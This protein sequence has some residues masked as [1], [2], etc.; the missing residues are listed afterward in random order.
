MPRFKSLLSLL[1]LITPLLTG[2]VL[3]PVES[4]AQ[5][6]ALSPAVI[7]QYSAK[8]A[9][10]RN[11]QADIRTRVACLDARDAELSARRDKFETALG[12]LRRREE[13]LIAE[14]N[15]QQEQQAQFRTLYDTERD[16]YDRQYNELVHYQQQKYAQE[17]A[18]RRCKRDLSSGGVFDWLTDTSC[19]L[20]NSIAHL[21]GAIQSVEG[22]IDAA[23]KRLRAAQ[24]GVRSAEQKLDESR[25]ALIATQEQSVQVRDSIRDT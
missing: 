1:T 8:L 25:N 18:V 5:D 10:A 13:P 22:R 9:D 17:E 11:L 21:V 14:L 15:R 19:D 2:T 7:S 3:V 23:E 16:N 6:E 24:E 12:D 20:A 4:M